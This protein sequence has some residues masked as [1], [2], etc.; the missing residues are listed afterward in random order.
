MADQR[1]QWVSGRYNFVGML[2]ERGDANTLVTGG[3]DAFKL[4][5]FSRNGMIIGETEDGNMT[6]VPR[7][8]IRVE[9][10]HG[11]AQDSPAKAPGI[12]LS[13]ATYYENLTEGRAVYHW[14]KTDK[15]YAFVDQ[16][17]MEYD[18]GTNKWL[19]ITTIAQGSAPSDKAWYKLL[20]TT[21]PLYFTEWQ[22][23][24]GALVFHDLQYIY[25]YWDSGSGYQLACLNP[26]AW[27]GTT[28]YSRGAFVQND[29]G[30][31]YVCI[32]ADTGSGQ[33]MSGNSAASPG[34]QGTASVI[35]DGQLEWTYIATVTGA[36]T[37]PTSLVPGIVDLDGYLFVGET[38]NNARVYNCN[39][40]DIFTWTATDFISAETIGDQLARV[41]RSVNYLALMGD[42]GTEFYYNAAIATGSPL[43][44]VEGTFYWNGCIHGNTVVS[45][46]SRTVW[47]GTDQTGK[48][49]LLRLEGTTLGTLGNQKLEAI[50]NQMDPDKI[51]C[52]HLRVYDRDLYIINH[53]TGVGTGQC[54][55]VD[56]EKGYV[57]AWDQ[58]E[59]ATQF[60]GTAVTGGQNYD[61]LP[62]R[63]QFHEKFESTATEARNI[64]IHRHPNTGP[65][66][67]GFSILTMDET[68]RTTPAR[69]TGGGMENIAGTSSMTD[70]IIDGDG[71]GEGEAFAIRQQRITTVL[72]GPAW[73]SDKD[74]NNNFL[75]R[76]D[77]LCDTP[78]TTTGTVTLEW[79]DDDDLDANGDPVLHAARTI[80]VKKESKFITRLGHTSNRRFRLTYRPVSTAYKDYIRIKGLLLNYTVG[81]PGQA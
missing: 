71:D 80:N 43:S 62:I 3:A 51:E 2:G 70:E 68:G 72:Q 79:Q 21:G 34:P 57:Y 78:S 14:A 8:P 58:G 33:T 46:G 13:G 32:Q 9:E 77:L 75:H 73:T 15:T 59:G 56:V 19:S 7:P 47:I 50:L 22:G 36:A 5:E 29:N 20:T 39:N 16:H 44:R 35:E 76:V 45:I 11:N 61:Y 65:T 10:H 63:G 49:K 30:K 81:S 42:R 4:D 31:I 55:V 12:V 48:R 41:H 6:W 1:S 37:I 18:E 66:A 28:S 17:F 74:A 69:L 23:S 53:V 40:A 26:P 38:G 60:D 54:L 67:R 25:V 27:Q 24:N 64:I 52:M